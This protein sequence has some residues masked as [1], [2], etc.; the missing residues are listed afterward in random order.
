MN[1]RRDDPSL[2]I[3]SPVLGGGV[4]AVYKKWF[5]DLGGFDPDLDITG[6]EGLETSFRAWQCGGSVE[7]IPC[8]RVGH[9]T[10]DK[11]PYTFPG[12]MENVQMKN[13]R[14]VVEIWMDSFKGND[15]LIFLIK[16]CLLKRTLKI[17]RKS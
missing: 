16:K 5:D 1:K 8:S 15:Q 13:L 12:G 14:R 10:R 3:K 6:A 7:I 4:F 9:L 11:P 2:P 17:S